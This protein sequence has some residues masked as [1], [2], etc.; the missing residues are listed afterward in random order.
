VAREKGLC[1]M[2]QE[3]AVT[4]RERGEVSIID[5]RGDL[6]AAT[7]ELVEETYQ[8]VTKAGGQKILFVFD[9]N[10]YINSAGIA[11]LVSI[12][13]ESREQGQVIRVTGLS[14]HFCKIFDMVGLAK[15]LTIFPSE[16]L[17]LDGF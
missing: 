5:L 17:A 2:T 7:G 9:K 12:T 10:N 8:K 3:L 14:D 1:I 15:Y 13:A 6:T 4:I 16:E 11:V